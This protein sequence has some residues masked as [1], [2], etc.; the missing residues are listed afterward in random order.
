MNRRMDNIKI[1]LK[2]P[3]G[4]CGLDSSGSKSYVHDNDVLC[5]IKGEIFLE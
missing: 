5:S 1:D 4:R 2:E 3:G